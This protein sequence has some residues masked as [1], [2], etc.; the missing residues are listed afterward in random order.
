MKRTDTIVHISTNQ[1]PNT[2]KEHKSCSL[3]SRHLRINS[4]KDTYM[5]S[6]M[7]PVDKNCVRISYKNNH[8][9]VPVEFI[10][11]VHPG[12][13][14]LIL[15]YVNQDITRAFIEAKHSEGAIEL[16]EQ[17]ME[18]GAAL[19]PSSDAASRGCAACAVESLAARWRRQFAAM[20]GAEEAAAQQQQ[21]QPSRLWNAFVFGIAG[22]TAMAAVLR[23]K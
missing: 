19:I 6:A 7:T 17:W 13:Q 21:Q 1:I 4:P 5:H 23:R 16:L 2:G 11:R 22:A 15:P 10:L 18:G 14:K 9:L 12:G 8:Y 20:S 3:F